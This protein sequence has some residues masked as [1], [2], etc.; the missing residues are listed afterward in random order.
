MK[1]LT[2]GLLLIGMTALVGCQK[3]DMSKY[4]K[5]ED[6]KIENISLTIKPYEWTW[7]AVYKSW[8]YTLTH[9]SISNDALV[10]YVMKG[11]G[12][13]ALPY[14]DANTGVTYGLVDY[15]IL[16]RILVTYYDGTN[17]LSA[18]SSDTYV[19][20]KIIPSSQMKP[21]VDYTD[22]EEVAEAHNF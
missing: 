18:P 15:T 10:G 12:K 8:Q 21:N 22:F 3:E 19:Y 7:N 13:Q 1:N 6:V 5:K 16:D 4:V 14:Y 11:Q 9:E 20:L 2:I 17:S